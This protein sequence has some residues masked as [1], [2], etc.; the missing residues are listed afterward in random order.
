MTTS[1]TRT[2]SPTPT[3]T[4]CSPA[5]TRH[6]RPTR[7]RMH[8]RDSADARAAKAQ[9]GAHAP[10]RRP[11]AS[12]VACALLVCTGAMC[13]M[14]APARESRVP[15]AAR[16]A[17]TP[18]TDAEALG[19]PLVPGLYAPGPPPDRTVYRCGNTY[20]AQ[21]CG[22]ARPLDVDD[23]R[24][25]SQRRQGEDVA[26]RDKRL[27]AWLEAQRRER[28]AVAS[29]PKGARVADKGCAITA[30]VVVVCPK[31]PKWRRATGKASTSGPSTAGAPA[32]AP[33]SVPRR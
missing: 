26:A 8:P 19:P 33:I 15:H 30:A 13:C 1:T 28:D 10:L 17:S 5:R 22:A 24:T 9:P 2:D 29:A 32:P 16:P 31:P 14:P 6:A 7:M 18:R 20:S 25:P 4:P 11:H 21:A 23:A 27:A 3:P 12:R